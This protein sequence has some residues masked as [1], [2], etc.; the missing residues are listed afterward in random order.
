ME[1][2][3]LTRGICPVCEKKIMNEAK[4]QYINNGFEFWVKFSD[5]SRAQFAICLDCFNAITQEQLDKIMERQKV[6]WGLE[7]QAQLSWFIKKAVNLKIIKFSKDKN[8]II[9]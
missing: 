8:G 3:P 1:I 4:T 7:I 9:S 6:S 5:G 2:L